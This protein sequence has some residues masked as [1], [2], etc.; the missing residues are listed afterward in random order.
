LGKVPAGH[1]GVPS[2]ARDRSTSGAEAV[3]RAHGVPPAGLAEM[4]VAFR[5]SPVDLGGAA[6]D[7]CPQPCL[8]GR[9][10][11]DSQERH[12]DPQLPPG[13]G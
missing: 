9:Q 2:F 11:S 4:I 13:A 5:P 3:T 1:A 7:C 8:W 6:R 10:A 12:R